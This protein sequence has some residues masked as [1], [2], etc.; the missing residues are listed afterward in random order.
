VEHLTR[1]RA[2]FA[3]GGDAVRAQ[4]AESTLAGLLA[5]L[6]QEGEALQRAGAA[7]AD[8]QRDGPAGALRVSLAWRCHLLMARGRLADARAEAEAATV[9]AEDLRRPL[10]DAFGVLTRARIALHTGDA[11]EL[12]AAT[13][14]ARAV[15]AD[16]SPTERRL[17]AWVRVLAALAADDAA[18]AAVLLA[19][20]ELPYAAPHLPVDVTLQPQV[21]RIALAAGDAELARRAVD[22]A[23]AFARENPEVPLVAAAAAHAR[24]LVGADPGL[25]GDAAETYRACDRPLLLAAA[26]EDQAVTL[27]DAGTRPERVALLERALEGFAA[28]GA[29]WDAAR[30]RTRLR[31]LGVRR[32]APSRRRPDEGW[33]SLTDS[34]RGVARLVGLGATNREAA[35]RLAVSPH[36]VSSHLR[37][38]F[39]KLGINSR[40]ELARIVLQRDH[41]AAEA[42]PGPPARPP[43]T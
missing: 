12:A 2:G 4:G 37:H 35:E 21:A 6:G 9:I 25:V 32:R 36:T 17:T 15:P 14:F 19:D 30:V 20:D 8:A 10:Q 40:V 42:E 43:V 18:S 1:A 39:T 3:A 7:I 34:E 31:A 23:V 22:L 13:A 38:T 41:E 33:D 28:A 26:L 5:E 27:G 24:G 11:R 29:E 16:A